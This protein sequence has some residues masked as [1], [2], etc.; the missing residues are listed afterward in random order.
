ML[1]PW[2][3][4]P[5][6]SARSHYGCY[7]SRMVYVHKLNV[8]GTPSTVLWTVHSMWL[9]VT[10][11]GKGSYYKSAH[12]TPLHKMLQE[13]FSH[14]PEHIS[15]TLSSEPW[16]WHVPLPRKLFCQISI[17]IALKALLNCHH[18]MKAFL[19]HPFQIAT[20]SVFLCHISNLLYLALTCALL[21]FFFFFLPICFFL[22]RYLF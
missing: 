18:F 3:L 10:A 6:P 13:L 12:I 16:R 11:P 8:K 4:L 14:L 17:Q 19:G 1:P 7:V 2:H 15:H 5:F 20:V 9:H 21:S 22:T